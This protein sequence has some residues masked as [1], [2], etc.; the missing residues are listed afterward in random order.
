[1][2]V[3]VRAVAHDMPPMQVAFW[4]FVGSLAVLLIG[5]GPEALRPRFAPMR[6]LLL[7]GLLG[8]GAISLWFTGIRDVGAAIATMLHSTYPV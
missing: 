6:I 4:R 5:A 8:A 1:M 7:R 3:C 2:T